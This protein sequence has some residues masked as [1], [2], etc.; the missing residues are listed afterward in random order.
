MQTIILAG[1]CFWGLE[2]LFRHEPGVV[3]TE[4]DNN[5]G[6]TASRF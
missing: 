1:G 3:A 6:Q 4:V 5:G 2:E